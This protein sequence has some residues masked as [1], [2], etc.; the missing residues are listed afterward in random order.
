MNSNQKLIKN[1]FILFVIFAIT[2]V[3]V[4]YFLSYYQKR[5]EYEKSIDT[6]MGFLSQLKANEIKNYITENHDIMIYISN[7]ADDNY[8]TFEKQLK[9]LL[10]AKEYTKDLVYVDFNQMNTDLLVE[11]KDYMDP[12]LQVTDLTVPNVLLVS[13][14]KIRS[15]LYHDMKKRNPKDVIDF[16]ERN[17]E[18][19]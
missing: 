3:L 15:I 17:M 6:R 10:I 8:R 5:Q 9:K 4:F 12:S 18:E 2:V 14:G 16:M 13:D 11:L 1:Y 19:A 7:S